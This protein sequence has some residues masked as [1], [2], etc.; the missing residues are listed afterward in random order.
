M[1]SQLKH[2]RILIFSSL[3]KHYAIL[4]HPSTYGRLLIQKALMVGLMIRSW[5][6]NKLARDL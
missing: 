3:T 2:L 5:L 1:F 4:F 6:V